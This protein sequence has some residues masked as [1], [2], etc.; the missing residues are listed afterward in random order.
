MEVRGECEERHRGE[1]SL[2]ALSRHFSRII[3]QR[4][5]IQR[6]LSFAEIHDDKFRD[7]KE[8]VRLVFNLMEKGIA[9]GT[10]ITRKSMEN[11]VTVVYALGGST[12][13]IL[14]L[15]AIA[16]EA[17]IDLTVDDFNTI[18]DRVPLISRLKPHGKYTYSKHLND[19]GGL[20]IGEV[21]WGSSRGARP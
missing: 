17:K 18:G 14:H 2:R 7:C 20:S 13:T 6:L 4:L 15:L 1:I 21:V 11:A 5:N 8:S 16:Y 9:L 3:I 12:N 10:I 19:L